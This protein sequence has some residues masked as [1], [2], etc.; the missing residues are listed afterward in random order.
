[1][2]STPNSSPVPCAPR[3]TLAHFPSGGTG[4]TR[5]DRPG[6]P[7]NGL[8]IRCS[9]NYAYCSVYLFRGMS[10]V[11]RI[12]L[13]SG[14]FCPCSGLAEGERLELSKDLRPMSVFWTAAIAV[15]RTFRMCRTRIALV[16]SLV[17][18]APRRKH[19]FTGRCLYLKGG[20]PQTETEEN[21]N[22]SVRVPC[23][24]DGDTLSCKY[25]YFQS[26]LGT[27]RDICGHKS[28]ILKKSY[29]EFLHLPVF[30]QL[31][32][33]ALTRT[34]KIEHDNIFFCPFFVFVVHG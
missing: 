8:A 25:G 12:C 27:F 21:P 26:H 31:P 6:T 15:R 3:I 33:T 1:M 10:Q 29:S 18:P 13:H 14:A 32:E 7:V 23:C 11:S 5:T 28:E 24:S 16:F 34:Q 9:T 19:L 2:C 4:R 30:V 22:I 17:V 20:H